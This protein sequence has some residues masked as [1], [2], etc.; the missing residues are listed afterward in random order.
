MVQKESHQPKPEVVGQYTK[1]WASRVI[2]NLLTEFEA[3]EATLPDG[4]VMKGVNIIKRDNG[5]VVVG[6]VFA[7]EA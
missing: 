6:F 5:Q 7:Q 4:F 2:N 1:G 3:G